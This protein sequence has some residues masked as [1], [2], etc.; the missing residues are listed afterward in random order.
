M[1][2]C[3]NYQYN[4]Q[5]KFFFTTQASGEE[6]IFWFA[7]GPNGK[8]HKEMIFSEVMFSDMFGIEIPRSWFLSFKDAI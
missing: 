1:N 6:G 3:C 4:H 7:H 2:E 8:T 5:N